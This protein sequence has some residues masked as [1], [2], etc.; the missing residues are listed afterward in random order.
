[1]PTQPLSSIA[2]LRASV[3]LLYNQH[4]EVD[5]T[6]QTFLLIW[7][8][9][10]D[11]LINMKS[12]WYSSHPLHSPSLL[13]PHP[14]ANGNTN[15]THGTSEALQTFYF[16]MRLFTEQLSKI[17]KNSNL[18]ALDKLQSLNHNLKVQLFKSKH[19]SNQS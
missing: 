1:M 13:P 16:R 12:L 5:K 4:V 11:T 2:K 14:A 7:H 8:T 9:L 19:K 10:G 17:G 18:S 15:N 6:L 3:L